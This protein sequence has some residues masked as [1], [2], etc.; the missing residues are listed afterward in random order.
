MRDGRKKRGGSNLILLMDGSRDFTPELLGLVV[1][2][3]VEGHGAAFEP[4]GA[5][6]P[7]G[8]VPQRL[9]LAGPLVFDADAV[10]PVARDGGQRLFAQTQL[11]RHKVHEVGAAQH[12]LQLELQVGP[13]ARLLALQ[14]HLQSPQN[15]NFIS[16]L[17]IAT[18]SHL[19]FY[20]LSRILRDSN[21]ITSSIH[22]E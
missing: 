8:G 7:V 4:L 14:I 18:E 20:L 10:V 19:Y 6:L 9:F 16:N 17:K 1:H 15:D 2:L 13:V 12:R 21:G 11:A 3:L 22:F 5:N